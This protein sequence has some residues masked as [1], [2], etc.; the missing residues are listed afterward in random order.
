MSPES[1]P[2]YESCSAPVC[3]LDARWDSRAY[4]RGEAVCGLVLEAVKP[5]GADSVRVVL[6][7]EA[8]TA[9]VIKA[10]PEI[11]QRF[12]FIARR[13]DRASS[14]GSRVR[15]V[16]AARKGSPGLALNAA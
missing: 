12:P 10:A 1:C 7:D 14:Q 9:A 11:A 6:K 16:L 8:A 5:N 3:P 15:S 13:L 2:R 4:V